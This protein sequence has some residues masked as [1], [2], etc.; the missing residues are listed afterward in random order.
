MGFAG[1]AASALLSAGP[2]AAAITWF[3]PVDST[4][5]SSDVINTGD[6]LDAGTFGATTTVNGVT[7]QNTGLGVPNTGNYGVLS[8][9]GQFSSDWDPEYR[10]LVASTAYFVLPTQVELQ[11]GTLAA[12]KYMMQLFLPQWDANWATAFSLNG[13]FSAPVQAGGALAGGPSY[14]G[15]TM[16]QWVKVEF[17]AD[18]VTEYAI[19]TEGVT[20]YQLLSAFQLRTVPST[21]AVP[22]PS[23]WAMMILGFGLAGAA[24]RRR[25]TLY[26]A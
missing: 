2:A 4:G 21:A 14:P 11:L 5:K 24:C 19:R 15:R 16:P 13:V 22:E 3:A 1:L 25:R 17:D 12:G 8:N 26:A 9:Y 20:R 6:L 10:T 18:G 7:F 23:T